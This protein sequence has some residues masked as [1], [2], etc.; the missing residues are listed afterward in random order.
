MALG[1]ESLAEGHH[2]ALG[3]NWVVKAGPRD[4]DESGDESVGSLPAPL[5]SPPHRLPLLPCAHCSLAL[6]AKGVR[7]NECL[8]TGVIA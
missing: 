7:G 3:D 5:C 6:A 4:L 1:W 8:V 2:G